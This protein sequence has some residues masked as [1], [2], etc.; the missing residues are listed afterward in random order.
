MCTVGKKKLNTPI[1]F[2]TNY[3]TE[4]KLVPI[5]MDNCL[6]QFDALKIFLGGASAWGS[7]PNFNFFNATPRIRQRKC[8]VRRL[9]CLNTNVHNISDISLR[10]SRCRNHN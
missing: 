10:D 2:N 9:N 5:I 7:L 6:L 4:M 8:K 3:F 1:Y